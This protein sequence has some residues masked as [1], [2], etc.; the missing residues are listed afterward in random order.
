[1]TAKTACGPRPA[2][3]AP[4]PRPYAVRFHIHPD[5]RL[6]G[7][8]E[9]S[10]LLVLPDGR[11]WIFGTVDVPIAIEE[12]ISFA[13]SDGP[14]PCDQ[15]VIYSDTQQKERIAWSLRRLDQQVSYQERA[16]ADELVMQD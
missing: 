11:R 5:V 3:A 1:M 2:S 10:V 12:S 4:Q 13:T 8:D 9:R 16:A 7:I 6:D 15:L 14:S